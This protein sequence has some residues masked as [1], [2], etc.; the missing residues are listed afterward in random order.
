MLLIEVSPRRLPNAGY[1]TR[2][3]LTATEVERGSCG[4]KEPLGARDAP[5]ILVAYRHGL[6][7]SELVD[8]H[9]DQ[10]DFASATLDVRRVKRGTRA[11]IRS[12]ATNSAIAS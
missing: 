6:R 2:E 4:Q 10:I 3:Y 9:W 5:M 8:L 11:R 1:R 12:W 7:V